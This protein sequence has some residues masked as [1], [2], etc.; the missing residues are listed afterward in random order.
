MT[1]AKTLLQ[2]V[3][4]PNLTTFKHNFPNVAPSG[5]NVVITFIVKYTRGVRTPAK[6]TRGQKENTITQETP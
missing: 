2:R 3:F 6:I 1:S 4:S 5:D